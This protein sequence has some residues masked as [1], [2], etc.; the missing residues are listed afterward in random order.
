MDSIS[1]QT[2]PHAARGPAPEGREHPA[3]F[4]FVCRSATGSISPQHMWGT[5]EAIRSLRN[6][7]PIAESERR[8]HPKLLDAFGFYFEHAPSLFVEIDEPEAAPRKR[9]RG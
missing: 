2:G 8:V 6:C 9:A 5:R 1:A 3:V 7:V 4:R